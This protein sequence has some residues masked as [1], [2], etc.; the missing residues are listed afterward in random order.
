MKFVCNY[1]EPY[2]RAY[3]FA[4]HARQNFQAMRGS[5]RPALR[6]ITTRIP[7]FKSIINSE[8][9]LRVFVSLRSSGG[10]APGIDRLTYSEF[11][12]KE[13]AAVLRVVTEA[14]RARTYRPYPNRLV[15][16]PKHDGRYRELRLAIVVD[17]VVASALHEAIKRFLD[18]RSMQCSFGFRPGLSSYHLLAWLERIMVEQ[19][20]WVLAIDDVA[21]AFPSMAIADVV[22]DFRANIRNVSI[23]WLLET[24]LRG[25]EGSTHVMGLPQGNPLSTVA[26]NLRML[27]CLDRPYLADPAN[28]PLLR[29]V[30]NLVFVC[31]GVS[32]GWESL[33]RTAQLLGRVGLRLKGQDGPP[34]NLRRQ[35]ASAKLLGFQVGQENGHMALHLPDGSWRALERTLAKAHLESSPGRLAQVIVEGWLTAMAP[36]FESVEARGMVQ[37]AI[38]TAARAGFRELGGITNL[39][40]RVRSGLD[41]WSA[42]RR[43]VA[44][45][46]CLR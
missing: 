18:R 39:E 14:I 40:S 2:E 5:V 37:R 34:V 15:L 44:R 24:L 33:N 7:S 11:S 17:R 29:Y 12:I 22:N 6:R 41:R 3:Y 13:I 38:T 26:L 20:R 43:K 32:E 28:P 30:D 8:N 45:E 1:C 23:C 27:N 10:A 35:G 19:N 16:I 31:N 25:D 42:V 9:L 36:A 21:D 4:R 46:T